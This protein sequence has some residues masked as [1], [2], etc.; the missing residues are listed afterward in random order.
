MPPPTCP[1]TL[2][3]PEALAQHISFAVCQLELGRAAPGALFAEVTT[4]LA[5]HGGAMHA[6]LGLAL[7]T[8][9]P[10]A[11]RGGDVAG[12]AAACEAGAKALSLIVQGTAAALHMVG[13]GGSG[14]PAA[15]VA[16][17]AR[18]EAEATA[19]AGMRK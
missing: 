16:A 14:G 3:L 19:T 13:L 4:L 18:A 5:A 9:L 12:A 2:T 6:L 11:A 8:L 10:P 1:N 17:A 7:A 15:A